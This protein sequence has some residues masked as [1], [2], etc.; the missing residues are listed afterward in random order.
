MIYSCCYYRRY[1]SYIVLLSIFFNIATMFVM[2]IAIPVAILAII[3]TLRNLAFCEG[4]KLLRSSATYL[5]PLVVG[6]K[7]IWVS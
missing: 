1:C 7:T 5:K 2:V 4:Q 3:M 6:K